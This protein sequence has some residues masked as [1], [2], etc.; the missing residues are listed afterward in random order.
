MVIALVAGGISVGVGV[1][2]AVWALPAVG[3]PLPRV[4]VEDVA[5]GVKRPLPDAHPVLV[6]YEDKDAQKQNERARQV[7]GKITDRP[8]NRA[9]FEFVAVA[10]VDAWNWWPAKK[11]VLADLKKIALK[12][13]TRLFA[14]WTGAVKK[15]WG[16]KPHKSV[17]LLAASD[18][19]VK[20]AAEGALTEAQLQALVAELKALG[21]TTDDGGEFTARVAYA[22]LVAKLQQSGGDPAKIVRVRKLDDL[23]RLDDG[24]RYKFVVARDGRL[25]VAPVPADAP[26]NEYVHPIL[27]G[28]EPVRTAGG[29]TIARD[30]SGAAANVTLDQDSKAY[31][32]TLASLDAAVRA[33]RDLGVPANAIHKQDRPPACAPQP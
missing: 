8:E 31:C 7:L 14:D 3:G 32:P 17:L 22:P 18:G 27:A 19:T 13:N 10:D 11:Y 29:I 30:T 6:M 1:A 16:F 24:K 33:L 20:F 28:G 9:R 5:A 4:E 23:A 25:S 15:A 21:S 26:G 2:P 12:E